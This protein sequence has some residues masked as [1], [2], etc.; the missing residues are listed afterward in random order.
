MK[1]AVC[2]G[3]SCSIGLWNSVNHGA[4]PGWTWMKHPTG[5]GFEVAPSTLIVF[6]R[7]CSG[8]ETACRA[9]L[10]QSSF[11]FLG[12][13]K[14]IRISSRRHGVDSNQEESTIFFSLYLVGGLDHFLFLHILGI[15][16]PIDFHI[17][18]RGEPTTNQIYIYIYIHIYIYITRH[19]MG[20]SFAMVD[21]QVTTCLF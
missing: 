7:S 17:F 1:N 14:I 9:Q 15:I 4:S 2:V 10:C 8:A 16:I 20:D 21:P 11:M 12:E 3:N 6:P 18:R 13:G 5:A 19:I